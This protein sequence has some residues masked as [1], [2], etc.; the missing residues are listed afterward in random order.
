VANLY[1]LRIAGDADEI[2]AKVNDVGDAAWEIINASG[3][4]GETLGRTETGVVVAEVWE[5]DEGFQQAMAH[6]VV[7]AEFARVQLPPV[8]L[9]G[10]YPVVRDYWPGR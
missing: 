6:P 8:Q 2:A 9:E 1:I 10:P 5:S 4:V 3:F 7:A